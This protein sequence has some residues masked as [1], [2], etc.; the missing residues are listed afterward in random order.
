[1]TINSHKTK[2]PKRSTTTS[3]RRPAHV[4]TAAH[5]ETGE[6]VVAQ[7]QAMETVKAAS[8]LTGVA[9]TLPEISAQEA[10]Q[11][12][13]S[14]V[15]RA[16]PAIT[17]KLLEQAL[18]GDYLYARM[19]FDFTGLSAGPSPVA[20]YEISPL[21]LLAAK[22]LGLPIQRLLAALPVAAGVYTKAGG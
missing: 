16:T 15:I 19:L 6:A 5:A 3:P 14:M 13:R 8:P 10:L 12:A 20:Q 7:D 22:E 1:M 17:A 4:K 2:S 9:G 18:E 21:V 11:R